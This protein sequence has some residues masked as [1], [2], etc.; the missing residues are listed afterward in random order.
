MILP[1]IAAAAIVFGAGALGGV[2]ASAQISSELSALL[3][4]VGFDAAI[5]GA[6]EAADA[7]DFQKLDSG[8]RILS[9]EEAAELQHRKGAPDKVEQWPRDILYVKMP[10]VAEGAHKG[11]L[12]AVALH[13]PATGLLLDLRGADGRNEA[14]AAKLASLYLPEGTPICRI[15]SRQGDY[16]RTLV[17]KGSDMPLSGLLTVILIDSKTSGLAEMLAGSLGGRDGILLVGTES[18]GA[19]AVRSFIPYGEGRH[20]LI[21]TGWVDWGEGVKTPVKPDLAVAEKGSQEAVPKPRR[22]GRLAPESVRLLGVTA[23]DRAARA[24]TDFILS[25]VRLGQRGE[26]E[27]KDTED[28]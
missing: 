12:E 26:Y 24:A 11:L 17:A 21:A 18:S 13:T 16:E 5:Y 14:E 10:A 6:T 4:E 1:G 9:R 2:G 19:S 23:E 25:Q 7:A 15:F 20:L 3:Q 22:M 27:G 8:A 28:K